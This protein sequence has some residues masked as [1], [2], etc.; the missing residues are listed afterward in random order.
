LARG[1]PHG[2][3]LPLHSERDLSRHVELILDQEN[4]RAFRIPADFHHSIVH[5]FSQ[6]RPIYHIVSCG[7][8]GSEMA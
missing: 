8:K 7:I 5:R 1:D 6:R 2:I 3:A 4:R